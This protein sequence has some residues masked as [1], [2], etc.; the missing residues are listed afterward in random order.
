MKITPAQVGEEGDIRAFT[1]I[2]RVRRK[3]SS[4]QGASKSMFQTQNLQRVGVIIVSLLTKGL[5]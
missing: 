2:E 4:M 1:M 3:T 5:V